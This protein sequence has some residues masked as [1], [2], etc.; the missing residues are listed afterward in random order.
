MTELTNKEVKEEVIEDSYEVENLEDNLKNEEEKN[1]Q[2]FLEEKAHSTS[3]EAPDVPLEARGPPHTPRCPIG[4]KGPPE[5]GTTT[6]PLRR[7]QL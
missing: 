6:C 1:Y 4:S 3:A 5:N 2:E 7:N